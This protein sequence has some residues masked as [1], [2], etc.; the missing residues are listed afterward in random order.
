[1]QIS[2]RFFDHFKLMNNEISNIITIRFCMQVCRHVLCGCLLQHPRDRDILHQPI[3]LLGHHPIEKSP[4]RSAI[5]IHKGVVIPNHEVDNDGLDNR[6]YKAS[7]VLIFRID[8][9]A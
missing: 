6:R 9:V 1:M 8:E 5:A 7:L 4:C 3:P 2:N